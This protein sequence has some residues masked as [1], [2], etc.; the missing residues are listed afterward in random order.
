MSALSLSVCE[1][2]ESVKQKGA[3]A[4]YLFHLNNQSDHL[5]FG[6]S[7]STKLIWQLFIRPPV[8]ELLRMRI[9]G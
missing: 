8:V 7:A 9:P 4:M 5:M 6:L 1:I 2:E 3:E